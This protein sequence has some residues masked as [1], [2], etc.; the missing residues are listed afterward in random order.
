MSR[1]DIAPCVGFMQRQAHKPK[2][3]HLKCINRVLR[4]CKRVKTG[5]Y[6]KKCVDPV[7][8][9]VIADAAYTSDED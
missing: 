8:V 2:N 7:R 5:M 4:Y 3:K 9:V 1:A 6:F